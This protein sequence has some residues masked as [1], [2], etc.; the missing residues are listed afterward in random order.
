[1]TEELQELRNALVSGPNPWHA[2]GLLNNPFPSLGQ[3]NPNVCHNQQEVKNEISNLIIDFKNNDF[4]L[5]TLLV[6]GT[7]RQG[8]TN[9]LA[10]FYEQLNDWRKAN[11]GIPILATSVSLGGG[12]ASSFLLFHQALVRTLERE[13]F[14]IEVLEG[15]ARS[16]NLSDRMKSVA[17]HELRSAIGSVLDVPGQP[18][19]ATVLNDQLFLLFS[20]WLAAER[21]SAAQKNKLGVAS[22]VLST[23]RATL[24]LRD[25]LALALSLQPKG[26]VVFV[27][28]FEEHA[29]AA[30]SQKVR[31]LQDLRNF[32]DVVQRGIALIIASTP[33]GVVGLKDYR[34]ID[35]RLQHRVELCNIEDAQEAVDYAQA[36]LKWGHQE[37]RER[38]GEELEQPELLLS[39]EEIMQ[40]FEAAQRDL[41]VEEA[42]Q[43]RFFDRLHSIAHQ[44][45]I[46]G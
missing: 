25:F 41:A 8:K 45:V 33:P 40:A 17:D 13:G 39:D 23:S 28:E 31:F 37:F 5:T 46:G 34:A 24:L 22:D 43:S 26:I 21:S 11:P 14:L 10:H 20:R 7:H 1:M 27:D 4:R 36:Y 6:V 9:V 18:E 3:V 12:I 38:M 16:P 30:R 29:L 32:M 2:Y 35:N 42:P 15:L 19:G 44:K